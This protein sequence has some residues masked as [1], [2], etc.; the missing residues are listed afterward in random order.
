MKDEIRF[1][2]TSKGM[3]GNQLFH[4]ETFPYTL[5]DKKWHM[6]ALSISG[7]EVQ[8]LIDCHPVYRRE[9]RYTPDRNFSASNLQLFVGQRNIYSQFQFKVSIYFIIYIIFLTICK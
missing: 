1:H 6:V 4:Y 3:N 7:T 5:A 2:Y 8:L 9:L